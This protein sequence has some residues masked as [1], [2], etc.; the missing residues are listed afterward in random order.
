MTWTKL[1]LFV[2]A[3]VVVVGRALHDYLLLSLFDMQRARTYSMSVRAPRALRLYDM[4]VSEFE[5]DLNYF[6][7]SSLVRRSSLRETS[8]WT[9]RLVLS[10]TTRRSN[11]LWII[12]HM[13]VIFIRLINGKERTE[14][15]THSRIDRMWDEPH[16]LYSALIIN[17]II[18][19]EMTTLIN[20]DTTKCRC[21]P[22]LRWRISNFK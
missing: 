18:E 21:T 12:N 19:N 3:V 17:Y 4:A 7:C 8:A 16:L 20:T 6:F 22:A 5:W 11:E 1:R 15:H 2:V 9:L 10:R 13:K 14:M